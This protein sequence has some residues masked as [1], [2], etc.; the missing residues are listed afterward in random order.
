[1]TFRRKRQL[2][3][4]RSAASAALLRVQGIQAGLQMPMIGPALA[5]PPAT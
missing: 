1:M 3:E 4:P 5:L 2:R